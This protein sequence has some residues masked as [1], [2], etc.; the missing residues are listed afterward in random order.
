MAARKL[1]ARWR[2]DAEHYLKQIEE[3]RSKNVPHT[4]MMGMASAL[5]LCAK[6]MEQI[7]GKDPG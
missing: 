5:R 3:A 2:R 7:V 4:C 1:C 6:E